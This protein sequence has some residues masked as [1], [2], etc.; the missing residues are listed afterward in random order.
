MYLHILLVCMLLLLQHCIRLLAEQQFGKCSLIIVI[1][2][3]EDARAE[4]RLLQL[5]LVRLNRRHRLGCG[6]VLT[7]AGRLLSLLLH[8]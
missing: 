6:A 7:L 2:I 4:W 3:L 1:I 8:I 5:L